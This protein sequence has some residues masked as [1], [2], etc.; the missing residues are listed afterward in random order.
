MGYVSV[1]TRIAVL[2]VFGGTPRKTTTRQLEREGGCYGK[3][4]AE[5]P[6]WHLVVY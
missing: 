6:N 5:N 3:K 4:G 1:Q 2:G